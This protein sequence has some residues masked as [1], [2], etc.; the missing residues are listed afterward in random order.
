MPSPLMAKPI[1]RVSAFCRKDASD[2]FI[3]LAI[4]LTGVLAFECC[5]SN[6]TS[7]VA[8]VFRTRFLVFVL[9]NL[10]LRETTMFD[11]RCR[12]QTCV[13]IEVLA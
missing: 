8:Y 13:R 1:L 11:G 9:A 4:F 2:R 5:L 3:N 6:L 7:A 12:P 10:L